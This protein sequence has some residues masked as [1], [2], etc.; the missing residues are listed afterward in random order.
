MI[1]SL[2]VLGLS[3]SSTLVLAQ[4]KTNDIKSNFVFCGANNIQ[5]WKAVSGQQVNASVMGPGAYVDLQSRTVILYQNGS[6]IQ[7]TGIRTSR[8]VV[9]TQV[10]G[11]NSSQASIKN[12]VPDFD[13][14][15]ATHHTEI[16]NGAGL[17]GFLD[18]QLVQLSA[19]KILGAGGL[20]ETNSNSRITYAFCLPVMK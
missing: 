6:Q 12:D 8:G 13:S 1:K 18:F 3:L 10:V 7:L 15:S 17:T 4:T 11:N 2:I 20:S 19:S 14:S 9:V 5:S 16:N